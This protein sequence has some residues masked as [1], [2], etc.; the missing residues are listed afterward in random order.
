[1]RPNTSAAS[2]VPDRHAMEAYL[3]ASTARA[4][5]DALEKAQGV[6]YEAWEQAAARSRLAL[7]RKALGI[8]PLCADAYCLL[9]GEAKT[10]A[11]ARALYSRGLDAGELALGPDGFSEY[12]GHFWGFLETRPYMRAR[13]GLALTLLRLGEEEAAISHFRAMLELNPDDNQGIRYLLLATLLRREDADAIKALLAQYEDDWSVYWLYTRALI[14][15]REGRADDSSTRKLLKEARSCNEH[16]PGILAGTE[17]S[18]T[19]DRG[20]ITAGGP[21]EATEYVL[22]CGAAWRRIPGAVAWLGAA[23]ADGR[24]VRKPARKER[25]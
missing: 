9:A 22:D 8:S 24:A 21:E 5:D 1:M 17:P 6:M 19:T 20:Y 12:A 14:A 13:H 2:I 3:A 25:P 23:E 15:F 10:D 4:R 16:V 18:V 11:E 7:A